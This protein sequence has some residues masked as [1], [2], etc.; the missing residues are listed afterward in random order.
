MKNITRS[1]AIQIWFAVVALIV[2]FAVTF[3]VSVT[4]G[5]GVILLLVLCLVPGAILWMLWPGVQ[6]TTVGD[7]IR[8]TDRRP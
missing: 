4:V 2:V 1:R 5:T 6:P 8:G 7:V 3:G